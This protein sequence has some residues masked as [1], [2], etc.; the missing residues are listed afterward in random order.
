MTTVAVPPR[1]V[2]RALAMAALCHG[3]FGLA[4][5]SMAFALATGMQIGVG[6]LTGAAAWLANLLLVAQF[7]LV[8]SWL[9]GRGRGWLARLSPF[10]HGS[11]LAPSTYAIS[12]SLQ[13]LAAFWLWSPSGVVWHAPTGAFGVGQWTLFACA[14]LFLHKALFDAGLMLQTGAAGW[15]ALLRGRKV[16]YGDMPTRGLFAACRQPIYLGFALVLWTAPTPLTRRGFCK[17]CRNLGLIPLIFVL[18]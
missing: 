17:V 6:G 9:L 5:G 11:T 10:G 12:A 18:R 4:V 1:S 16:D 13:L 14:W 3:V 2:P 15:W 7:P 8:H